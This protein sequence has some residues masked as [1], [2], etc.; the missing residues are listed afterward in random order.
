[1]TA[2]LAGSASLAMPVPRPVTSAA[3]W[4]VSAAM[5]AEAAVV[6]PMPISPVAMMS[7][8]F[9]SSSSTSSMPISMARTASSRV[10]AGPCAML[11]VP[12]RTFFWR[13]PCG[14]AEVGV[15]AHVG[16][17]DPG[18]DVT[19]DDVDAGA[20]GGEVED[21]RRRDLGR[22]GADALGGHPVVGGH[23]GD[24]LVRDDRLLPALDAGELDGQG[25][26][27]AERLGRL[28]ELQLPRLGGAHGV[29]VEGADGGD[30]AGEKV[31][32]WSSLE[33]DEESSVDWMRG[34]ASALT[35]S[36]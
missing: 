28:G 24:R 21:H 1:M 31:G 29:G 34:R 17:D 27:T 14:G 35:S 11:A 10:I 9:A 4:P 3:G 32:H 7:R 30:G 33:G 23:D 13:T 25:L 26:E 8:P 2:T 6:L 19:A 15:H 22:E 18:A 16:D 36:G 12:M 5:T 20:A